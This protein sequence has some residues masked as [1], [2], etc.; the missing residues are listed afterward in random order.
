MVTLKE[1]A[2]ETSQAIEDV[3]TAK[4]KVEHQTHVTA[5][6][7]KNGFH[8]L[9]QILGKSEVDF[10]KEIESRI[11]LFEDSKLPKLKLLWLPVVSLY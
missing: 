4:L 9:H 2:T 6:K 7:I 11:E 5:T 3:R 8:Q 10:Y 1:L